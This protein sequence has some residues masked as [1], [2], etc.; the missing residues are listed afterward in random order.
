[1]DLTPLTATSK[2]AGDR[3]GGFSDLEIELLEAIVPVM[4]VRM[5]LAVSRFALE[6]LLETYLGKKAA[7]RVLAGEFKRGAGQLVA[8]C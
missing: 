5:E 4:S 1:M 8:A 2:H 6:C 3:P 7:E